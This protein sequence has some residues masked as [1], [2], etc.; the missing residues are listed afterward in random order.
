M[1]LVEVFL[2]ATPTDLVSGETWLDDRA[3]VSE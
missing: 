3:S 2:F 1:D